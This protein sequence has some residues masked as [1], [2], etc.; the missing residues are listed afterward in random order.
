MNKYNYLTFLLICVCV[1]L[2]AQS[3]LFYRPLENIKPGWN[4]LE[5]PIQIFVKTHFDDIRILQIENKDTIE[6]PYFIKIEEEQTATIVNS[7][8]AFNKGHNKNGY[9]Y[10]FKHESK[11]LINQLIVNLNSHNYDFLVDL[12]GSMDQKE[13]FN[14]AENTRFLD[15][16]NQHTNY[17]FSTVNFSQSNYQFYRLQIKSTKDPGL[18]DVKTNFKQSK[19]GS[20]FQFPVKSLSSN[21]I[22]DK[23]N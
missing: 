12:Q 11:N 10:T 13:W 3:Q 22:K 7:L 23:K 19:P 18:F 15:I 6:V 9:F 14:I 20:Y 17:A 16:Q 5:I 21:I 4:S 2:C 1:N 8:N